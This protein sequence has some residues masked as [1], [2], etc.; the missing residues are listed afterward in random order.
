MK[1]CTCGG[2][3][4][5]GPDGNCQPCGVGLYRS[6]NMSS[7]E[8][9]PAD[10]YS[11]N[12]EGV[13]V[14]SLCFPGSVGPTGSINVSTCGCKGGEYKSS[15]PANS[16]LN[17]TFACLP[18]FGGTFKAF[19]GLARCLPCLAGKFSVP[20][21]TNCTI[22]AGNSSSVPGSAANCT[23]TGNSSTSVCTTCMCDAGFTGADGGNC[24]SC[25]ADTFKSTNGSAACSNCSGPFMYS[26]TTSTAES[27][28][29]RMCPVGYTQNASQDV[30]IGCAAGSFKNITGFSPCSK[31]EAGKYSNATGE[32]SES[33]CDDCP[34]NTYSGSGSNVL[35][36]C[37]CN[38]GYTGDDGTECS[39]CLAGT[40]KSVNGTS[41]CL[42]CEAGKFTETFASTMCKTCGEGVYS[43]KGAHNC[44]ECPEHSYSFAGSD[45][46]TQ[47]FCN[48][49]Y[50]TVEK[51]VCGACI[52]GTWKSV[53]GS[54]ACLK[55]VEG[56]YSV[57]LG[58]IQELYC[59]NCTA[60]SNSFDGSNADTN[61]SCNIGY[62]GPDSS[63]ECVAC[64]A[65]KYKN[66]SGSSPC[67][68]CAVGK[69]SPTSGAVTILTCIECP[70]PF[71]SWYG[72]DN[73]TDCSE[74]PLGETTGPEAAC[75][76]CAFGKYKQ[77]PGPS[78]CLP[79]PNHST[80]P[81]RSVS[82]LACACARGFGGVIQGQG[83]DQNVTC[84]ICPV[85]K[86]K[87]YASSDPC[88]DCPSGS[89]SSQGSANLSHCKC[90]PGFFGNPCEQCPI[91]TFK[92]STGSAKC[93]TCAA[94]AFSLKG[95]VSC[96]CLPGYA[97]S[98][99]SCR[100]C[101]AGSYKIS[102]GTGLCTRCAVGQYSETNAASNASV[103][104]TCPPHSDSP[105]GSSHVANCSCTPEY[106]P[107][108]NSS[109]SVECIQCE[110]GKFKDVA[111][112]ECLL[113]DV[114][115]YSTSQGDP[116]TDCAHNTY[117]QLSRLGCNVC[118][119]FSRSPTASASINDCACEPGYTGVPASNCS[120]C[121][122]G[123]FKDV[124]GSAACTLCTSGK[125]SPGVAAVLDM[126]TNCTSPT[127]W[128]LPGGTSE[129]LHCMCNAGTP[130]LCACVCVRVCECVCVYVCVCMRM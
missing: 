58:A 74:C 39:E 86:F 32:I 25:P 43:E 130:R 31:C 114:G 33:A 18:C 61:C 46:F 41:P 98:K 49:G 15:V 82:A 3:Y 101:L 27:A 117:S 9:C 123:T 53:N 47:C 26:P 118:P 24:S 106:I 48:V 109:D 13:F 42:D 110:P 91:S 95:S 44:T 81:E 89:T 45:N 14:C 64:G 11:G 59:L 4:V 85:A 12:E 125:Y 2:G 36:N 29:Y 16:S 17:T 103:C 122:A 52:A 107:W 94:G 76:R 88:N 99:G 113:C 66:M 23:G 8:P 90:S 119:P 50:T 111:S 21:A 37:S 105:A 69:Y 62:R 80:S 5:L 124:N 115:K 68:D 120:A 83:D 19:D 116:C 60:N 20:G 100:A 6:M 70:A 40:R 75:V 72:S 92:N 22:C 87:G 28:C 127:A 73:V 35:A 38:A 55:C 78:E 65:G 63:G 97:G 129:S 30:C 10:T 77:I 102:N 67:S 54:S 96:V 112:A 7:C 34:S 121:V 51:G 104:L 79:C 71:S 1:N 128:S 126:C 84:E 56:K 57:T 93:L 108:Y